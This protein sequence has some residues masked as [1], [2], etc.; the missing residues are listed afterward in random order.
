MVNSVSYVVCC[1]FSCKESGN[2]KK[3]LS[4]CPECRKSLNNLT[5]DLLN[6]QFCS[7]GQHCLNS[8]QLLSDTCLLLHTTKTHQ[9]PP[10][11]SP[12]I[13]GIRCTNTNCL[14]LHPNKFGVWLS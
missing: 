4:K 8:S 5:L 6:T 13:N 14:F 1:H 3:N 11:I 2:I 10:Y 7:F 9:S 12:C